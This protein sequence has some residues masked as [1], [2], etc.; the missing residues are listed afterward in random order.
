MN[1][2]AESGLFQ[3]FC[4]RPGEHVRGACVRGLWVWPVGVAC[5]SWGKT[6]WVWAGKQFDMADAIRYE[7]LL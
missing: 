5:V 1:I 3:G 7:S 2:L 6:G 4:S